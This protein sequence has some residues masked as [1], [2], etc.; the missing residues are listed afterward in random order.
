MQ[1]EIEPVCVLST[2]APGKSDFWATFCYSG[3]KLALCDMFS[4]EYIF[5]TALGAI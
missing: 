3:S 5:F 2:S 1:S 4:E